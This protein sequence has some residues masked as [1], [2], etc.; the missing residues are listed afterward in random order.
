[1]YFFQE[2]QQQRGRESGR[3]LG[4]LGWRE[5]RREGERPSAT[6]QLSPPN[7]G[8]GKL[9]EGGPRVGGVGPWD[10]IHLCHQK[11]SLCFGTDMQTPVF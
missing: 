5:G 3:G 8:Q 9:G 11:S 2:L 4:K 7:L 6:G 1:M 10:L